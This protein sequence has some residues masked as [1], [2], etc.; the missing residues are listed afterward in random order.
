M[1][2]VTVELHPFGDEKLKR[3]LGT[4]IIANDGKGSGVIGSYKVR[5]STF[6]DP[7]KIWKKGEVKG[8]H[9]QSKGPWDLLYL[10]LKNTVGGRN[11]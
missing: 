6:D 10:A 4:A 5:L 11:G 9:R 7:E 1:M 3:H 8:F 2:K